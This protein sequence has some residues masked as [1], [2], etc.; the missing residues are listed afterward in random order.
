MLAFEMTLDAAIEFYRRTEQLGAKTEE[1]CTHILLQMAK[2]GWIAGVEVT[3]ETKDEYVSR[4]SKQKKV[5]HVKGKKNK[6][7][8]DDT[9]TLGN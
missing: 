3:E 2:E 9:G 8:K 6:H 1:Q 5:L 4:M 7:R